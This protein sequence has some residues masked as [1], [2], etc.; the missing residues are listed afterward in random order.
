[1]PMDWAGNT[2]YGIYGDRSYINEQ[3]LISVL[4]VDG[5]PLS[6]QTPGHILGVGLKKLN[7][8]FTIENPEGKV[9]KPGQ[10]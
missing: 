1:M 3:L 10:N 5:R 2:S 8:K 9:I 4:D 6:P 7:W